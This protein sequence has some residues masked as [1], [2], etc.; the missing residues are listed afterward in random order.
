MGHFA[1]DCCSNPL[2]NISYMDTEDDDV[3]NVPQPNIMPRTNISYLKAQIDALSEKDNDALIE[4]MGSSQDSC[5]IRSAL[6]K[7]TQTSNVFISNRKSI[8]IRTFLHL[9]SKRANT[10][11]LLDSGATENFMNLE[12]VKYLHMPIQRL[13]EPRKLFNV[14]GTQ[15]RSGELQF[16]TDLQVQTGSQRTTLQFFLSNLGENK[17]I[18]GYPW[19]AAFQP[20]IDWKR[21]WIDHGQLP[22]ILRSLDASRAWFLPWQTHRTHTTQNNTTYICRL[23]TDPKDMP[24]NSNIPPPYQMYSRV[25]SEEASHEFPLS[26]PWDHMIELKPGAPAALPGK[27]IPLSQAELVELWSFVKE[28]MARGTIRPSKSPYKSQFFYIKKKDG[29]LRPVQDYRPVNEWTI[30]NA[31]PLPLIP[32]LIDRLSGCSLYTKFDIWWGYNNVHIKEG[33]EW[34]AAFITN[35]GLFEPTVMFFGLTNS[36]TTFQTMMNSIFADEIAERWLTVYMDDMAIHTQCQENE[37]EEQHVQWHWT[38]VKRILAKLMEHN[39]FLKPEKC[40]FEQPSIEFL[41]V[42]ITQGEVQMDDTKVEKVCNWRPPTNVTEVWKFLGFTGY[43][44]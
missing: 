9:R 41:G 19:F 39:L 1:K 4:A 28:H 16:F 18:L 6:I 42:R 11:A 26:R 10:V 27:L 35:E 25:F 17:V 20:K 8:T 3:Q 40:S 12:Y 7:H 34:K 38:Y 33:D 5:L 21:G 23:V 2:S 13:K 22:V 29:K 44:R 15:N 43:Y 32:E 36:P 30:C 37:T 14:N 31:Y 24:I